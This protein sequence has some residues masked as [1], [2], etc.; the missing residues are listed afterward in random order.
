MIDLLAA[1]GRNL[2]MVGDED[3]SIYGFRA[4]Y[5]QALVSFEDRHPGAGILLME[6]NYRSRQEIVRAA[7][8]LIQKNKNRHPKKMTAAREGGG[9]VT[10]IKAVS[11]QGQYNYLLKV[12]QDCEQETAVLYRNN[13]SALPIIDL[14]ERKGLSC[15][16]KIRI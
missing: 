14:L 10:E 5:P 8:T 3:Q 1:Q 4:A 12:A 9:C 6:T 13:E 11:R 16:V 15:R 7:D 2:F